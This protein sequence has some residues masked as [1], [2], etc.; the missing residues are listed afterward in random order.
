MH[1]PKNGFHQIRFPLSL[2]SKLYFKL[3]SGMVERR[4]T[5]ELNGKV[6]K[7][8]FLHSLCGDPRQIITIV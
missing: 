4:Q 8:P 5:W 2:V 1:W 6:P 7:I 3:S